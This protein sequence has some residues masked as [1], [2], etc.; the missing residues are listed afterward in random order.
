[1]SEVGDERSGQRLQSTF[2]TS[3]AAYHSLATSSIFYKI[4]LGGARR[5]GITDASATQNAMKECAWTVRKLK[6]RAS[7]R[8]HVLTHSPG[9]HTRCSKPKEHMIWPIG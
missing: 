1:M 6:N 7:K 5:R 3:C 8:Y 9:V 4:L 2:D